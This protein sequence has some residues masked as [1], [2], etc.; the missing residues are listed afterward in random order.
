MIQL[1]PLFRDVRM[2][3]ILSKV[4]CNRLKN[5]FSELVDAS[6]SAFIAGRSIQDNILIV[7]QLIHTIKKK[8]KGE[9]RESN[10]KN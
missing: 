9:V 1:L 7:F 2:Y 8:T 3:K 10:F 6:Q 5:V 4:L